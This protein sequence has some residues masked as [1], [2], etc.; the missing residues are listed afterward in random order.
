LD[1]KVEAGKF[2]RPEAPAAQGAG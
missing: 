2:R 1:P